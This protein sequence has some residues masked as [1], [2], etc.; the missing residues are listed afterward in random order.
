M[1]TICAVIN[2]LNEEKNIEACIRSLGPIGQYVDKV[3]VCDN[4]SDDRTVEIAEQCGAEVIRHPRQRM[5]TISRRF[6]YQHCDAEWVFAFDADERPTEALLQE[7]RRL[8]ERDDIQVVRFAKKQYLFGRFIMHGGWH[9]AFFCQFFRRQVYLDNYRSDLEGA[10]RDFASVQGHPQ[11]HLIP[12]ESGACLI[13]YAYDDVETFVHRTL[14][15]YS[16][17]EAGDQL[18]AGESWSR[19]KMVRA[20]LHEFWLRYFRV[21][22]YKDGMHGFV[23]ALL[24]ACYRCIIE[25]NKWFLVTQPQK[26]L[27]GEGL[28]GEREPNS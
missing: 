16:T 22:G 24:M 13:H 6:A 2:T 8:S 23:L 28:D 12:K 14:G 7:I 15:R 25:M 5:V 18:L 27:E 9:E 3:L 1:N 11:T 19:W 21:R 26:H 20:P 4:Y 17:I 10:H